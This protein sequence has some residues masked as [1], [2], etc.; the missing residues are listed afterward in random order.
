MTSVLMICETTHDYAVI[1][2]LMI[3]NL[4]SFFISAQLQPQPIYDA[5]AKQDGIH[6]PNEETRLHHGQRQVVQVMRPATEVMHPQMSVRETLEHARGSNLHAWPITDDSGLVGVIALAQIEDAMAKGEE[7][8]QLK[9]FLGGANF[10]HVHADH[11][12]HLAL[13]RMGAAKLDVLPVVSRA[14]IHQL[15]GIVALPDLI[16][17]FGIDRRKWEDP[18][19]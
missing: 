17:S 16:N 10:P 19:L 9:D 4:V 15:Q 2:P 1:V 7:S 3:S 14:N 13:E 8:K 12:L 18:A 6:L 5:L 11:P